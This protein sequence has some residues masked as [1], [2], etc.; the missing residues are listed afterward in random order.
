MSENPSSDAP[1]R[2]GR[3]AAADADV[4]AVA[5]AAFAGK[6]FSDPRLA[7]DW[8]T[9]VGEDV[10]RLTLPLRLSGGALTLKTEPGAAA[11]LSYETRTLCERINTYFGRTLV[12]RLKFVQGSLPSRPRPQA[13]LVP[14]QTLPENDPVLNYEGPD[15]LHAALVKLARAR[16]SRSIMPGN[17][18]DQSCGATNVPQGPHQ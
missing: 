9:I 18:P 15:R 13:R 17:S 1:K 12:V 3:A 2:R 5:K 11:F 10:A 14:P 4:C 8:S 7:L 6:G 16:R